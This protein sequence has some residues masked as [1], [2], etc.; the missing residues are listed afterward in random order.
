MQKAIKIEI[1]YQRAMIALL[2]AVVSF[3]AVQIIA[4]FYEFSPN[5]LNMLIYAGMVMV[6]GI[7]LKVECRG[8]AAWVWNGILFLLTALLA[9]QMIRFFLPTVGS[10]TSDPAFYYVQE[11][12]IS[13]LICLFIYLAFFVVVGRPKVAL[14][15]G[16][17]FWYIFGLI[18]FVVFQFRGELFLFPD[19][20]AVNTALDVAGNYQIEIDGSVLL[21]L[22]LFIAMNCLALAAG[23]KVQ[24]IKRKLL[25]RLPV[26]GLC[27]AL[28]GGFWF[29]N[30]EQYYYSFEQTQNE[31]IYAFAVSAKMLYPTPP[32]GYDPNTLDTYMTGE[33]MVTANAEGSIVTDSTEV[34]NPNVIVVMNE[35]FADLKT[36]G[37]FETNVDYMPFTRSLEDNTIKGTTYVSVFGGGTCDTEYS[38]LTGNTTAYLPANA[39]PYQQYVKETTPSIAETLKQQG[40]STEAIHPG[41]ADAWNR[42][43]VYPEMG[44]DSF[45]DGS[46]FVDA[47]Y[48]RGAWI[49]DKSCYDRIIADYEAGKATGQPQFIF[50]VTI[51]NHGGYEMDASDIEPVTITDHEGEF[52]EAEQYLSLMLESDKAFEYLVNYFSE[53]EEPTII[54]M[55]GDHQ[56]NVGD[57]FYEFLKGKPYD[58]WSDE[59]KLQRQMTP[60]VIWA[61]YD[62]PEMTLDGLSVNYLA[63]LL[64]KTA[65]LDMTAYD[66]YLLNLAQEVPVVVAGGVVDK[67][68]TFYHLGDS[69]P[70]SQALLEYEQILYN[71]II[72]T[73]HRRTELFTLPDKQEA[74]PPNNASDFNQ[75]PQESLIYADK[76]RR[77]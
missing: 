29:G 52:P 37:D 12:V 41:T 14:V 65:G 4:K 73:K 7:A 1:T 68:G 58:A 26:L 45:I 54:L 42:D 74:A 19:I 56:G 10:P 36:M 46:Q 69:L 31:Y 23:G 64:L 34:E 67:D 28:F 60:F 48:T 55:F 22:F 47:Q 9:Y 51:A 72:D 53:Q 32:S 27:C 11:R 44:F 63:P 71:N 35:S 30:A 57:A 2:I 59:E 15:L 49:S 77:T 62:I 38:F 70:Y 18:A 6:I 40:Y 16:N 21:A 33:P 13:Y 66:S 50:N 76:N 24:G 61:N 39:R 75:A 25:V 5:G 43:K 17:C 20:F 3:M 8:W